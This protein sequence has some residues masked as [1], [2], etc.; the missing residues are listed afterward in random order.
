MTDPPILTS[1][2]QSMHTNATFG[3]LE[4]CVYL[5]FLP[6][7]TQQGVY[8]RG[9]VL[10]SECQEDQMRFLIIAR[11]AAL[12]AGKILQMQSGYLLALANVQ[13]ILR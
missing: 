2:M 4:S 9:A 12:M 1:T 3:P 11:N 7:V 5:D 10:G 6:K 8:V 13:K